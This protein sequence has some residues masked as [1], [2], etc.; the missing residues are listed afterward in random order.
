MA[1]LQTRRDT[2]A[3]QPVR[4]T[5]KNHAILNSLQ[6]SAK[7]R[8][9]QTIFKLFQEFLCIKFAKLQFS[10]LHPTTRV[11]FCGLMRLC[12]SSAC[13]TM[14]VPRIASSS[15]PTLPVA[16]G[17]LVIGPAEAAPCHRSDFRVR[18]WLCLSRRW[19]PM[20]MRWRII[21]QLSSRVS[22]S[23]TTTGQTYLRPMLT[24]G[25]S[26]A[27]KCGPHQVPQL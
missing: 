9:F 5:G 24:F 22:V 4:Q 12:R 25:N 21:R 26:S 7:A 6:K 16:A 15:L 18:S 23:Q 14:Q 3:F 20:A 8:R 27:A 2:S 13:H 17:H 10:Y 19:H 1:I 11:T